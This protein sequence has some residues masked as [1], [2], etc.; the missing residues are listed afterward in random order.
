MNFKQQFENLGKKRLAVGGAAALVVLVGI[1]AL[2]RTG[3][4]PRRNSEV[5][6]QSRKNPTRYVTTPANGPA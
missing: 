5:S 6:S 4:A 2:T 3:E 1:M